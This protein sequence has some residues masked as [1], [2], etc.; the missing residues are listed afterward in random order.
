[1][2]SIDNV[3]FVNLDSEKYWTFPST[4]KGDIHNE[5]ER[6]ILS[7]EYAGAQKMDGA[8]YRLIKDMNGNIRLQGRSRGVSGEFLDKHEWVPHLNSFFERLPNGTCLLGEL[9]FPENQGSRYVTTVMGCLKNKA[10]ER[11]TEID[12]KLHYYV[13]DIWAWEGKSLLKTNAEDRFNR[14]AAI[15]NSSIF[16]FPYIEYATYYIGPALMEELKR[17][18][19]IDG[20]GIVIT[21]LNSIPQP[22]K[23]TARKTL[24][25]KK[26]LDNPI[27]CFLTGRY[28]T[29]TI[30]YTGKE[31]ETWPYWMNIKTYE[32]INGQMYP[33]YIL[34]D[35]II[36]ITKNYYNDWAGAIEIGVVDNNG[37]EIGIGWISGI[38]ETVRK[39]IVLN[40]DKWRYKVV[41]INAM[42]IEPDT[43]ALRHGR[44][45]EWRAEGDKN[46]DECSINQLL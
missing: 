41:K 11:Q 13:F 9:Y 5:I 30:E 20:E 23:R 32:K 46:W 12:K 40:P 15:S 25:I 45:L 37:K 36:P 10:I 33:R 42:D 34:G 28:K 43:H 6:M 24:K 8:Y 16:Q 19:T 1:M 38:T 17:V 22:G 18:R 35:T 39:E 14:L 44:I 31:L 2:T 7:N 26:E 4:F 27:D 21:K 29:A 3:D